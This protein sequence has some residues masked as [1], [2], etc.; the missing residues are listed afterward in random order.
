M[1]HLDRL[2][3]WALGLFLVSAG[4]A[5]FTT[6]HVFQYIEHQS[7]VDLFHPY[8]NHLTGVAELV[9]GVLILIPRTRLLGGLVAAGVLVGA[10]GFHLS[11]WLGISIPTGL[12]DGAAAP[13]GAEDFTT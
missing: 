6:G 1:R 11:P 5:K 8:V 12:V 2:L 3:T 4:V 9:A 7:G 10:V 13:W